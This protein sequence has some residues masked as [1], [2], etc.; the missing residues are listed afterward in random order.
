MDILIVY[1]VTFSSIFVTVT[2]VGVAFYGKMSTIVM[3]YDNKYL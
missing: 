2:I 3:N 1:F